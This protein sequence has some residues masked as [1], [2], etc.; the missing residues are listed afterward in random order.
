MELRLCATIKVL[1]FSNLFAN[2]SYQS[3]F[4]QA[5]KYDEMHPKRIRSLPKILILIALHT[6]HSRT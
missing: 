3:H 2:I 1:L 6:Q 5:V 4:P